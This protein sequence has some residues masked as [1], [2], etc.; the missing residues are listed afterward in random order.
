MCVLGMGYGRLAS[1]G[2]EFQEGWGTRGYLPR[3]CFPYPPVL[4]AKGGGVPLFDL[5]P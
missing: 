5:F 2:A 3:A 4:A 1:V